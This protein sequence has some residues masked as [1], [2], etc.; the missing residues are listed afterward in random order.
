MGVH[1]VERSAIVTSVYNRVL[2]EGP[3]LS[4]AEHPNRSIIRPV[5]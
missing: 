5:S 4:G 1:T 2:I 3:A